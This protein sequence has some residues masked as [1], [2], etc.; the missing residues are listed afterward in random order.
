MEL[1]RHILR[2]L[3]SAL[4]IASQVSPTSDDSEGSTWNPI[5]A[6]S[7]GS[8]V[9]V[10]TCPIIVTIMGTSNEQWR[11][12]GLYSLCDAIRVRVVP[13]WSQCELR[14]GQELAIALMI[15][16]T[17]VKTPRSSDFDNNTLLQVH[18]HCLHALPDG[19]QLLRVRVGGAPERSEQRPI[20]GRSHIGRR[21]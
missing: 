15:V 3:R 8:S 19:V 20:L 14:C 6:Y 1:R 21:L 13:L 11:G 18:T 5:I 7:I 17:V 10:E 16:G 2:L 4:Q 9:A 12:A